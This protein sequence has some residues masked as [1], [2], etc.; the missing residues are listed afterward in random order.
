MNIEPVAT[1]HGPMGEKFGLPRQ[2][3]LAPSLRGE[4]LFLPPYCDPDFVRGLE[5]FGYIWVIWAFSANRKGSGNVK[6]TVRPPRLGGNA[7]LGVF[8]TRSPYRPNLLALSCLK[9]E[10]ISSGPGKL[11]IQVSGADLMD[12]TPIYDIKPYLPYCDSHPDAAGGFVGDNPWRGLQ[13]DDESALLLGTYFD[14][15]S[16]RAIIQI[17]S[18]DP[19]PHYHDD[20]GRVYG[21]TYGGK[22]VRFRVEGGTVRITEVR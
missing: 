13:V 10:G 1:F 12:G 4:I 2:S 17:L 14:P 16:C 5:G 7:T 22:D 6:A 11:G 18:Q 15:E 9:V 21:M 3:G 19:R 8:A 20:P